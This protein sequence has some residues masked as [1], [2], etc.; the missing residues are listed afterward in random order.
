MK[1]AAQGTWAVSTQKKSEQVMKR[2]RQ[3]PAEQYD[4]RGTQS[5]FDFGQEAGA[6]TEVATPAA[7]R[8]A[9]SAL[10][11]PRTKRAERAPKPDQPPP[12]RRAGTERA[13]SPALGAGHRVRQ[14]VPVAVHPIPKPGESTPEMPVQPVTGAAHTGRP[15]KLRPEPGDRPKRV[16]RVDVQTRPA[17]ES[18]GGLP[19]VADKTATPRLKVQPA[20]PRVRKSRA[21]RPAP[22]EAPA[23]QPDGQQLPP[24]RAKRGENVVAAGEEGVQPPPST[25]VSSSPGV[26][27]P[28][29]P[30]APSSDTPDVATAPD[31]AQPGPTSSPLAPPTWRYV[32]SRD[33]ADRLYRRRFGTDDVPE[34]AMISGTW[35]YALPAMLSSRG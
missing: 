6:A 32:G 7:R 14:E 16:P 21:Q 30:V 17:V 26:H 27:V 28:D 18:T 15:A 20:Q 34:P 12:A 1:G 19:V 23:P 35:A 11:A 3:Q 10:P 22:S 2:A 8:P 29:P 9:V 33:D 24:A 4:I 5:A 13:G 31:E 25:A